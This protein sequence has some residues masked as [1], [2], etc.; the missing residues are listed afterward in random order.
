MD[1]DSSQ[2]AIPDAITVTHTVPIMTKVP[3]FENGRN[4]FRDILSTSPS[5]EVIAVTALKSTN[6]DGSPVI[7]ANVQTDTPAIGTQVLTFEALR[8]TETTAIE[9]T[10]TRI[11][12]LRTSFS[13]V[14]PSTIYNIRPVTTTILQEVDHNQLLSS[15]LLQLLGGQ[16][17]P[18]L[19]ALASTPALPAAL[20]GLGGNLGVAPKP[21]PATQF[22][23][24]TNTYVTTL[25][26]VE[27]TVL[28]ITLRGRE[29]KTTLVESKTEVVTATEFSTETIIA[30]T[31]VAPAL[32][33]PTQ[34]PQAA[35]L[36]GDLQQQLLLAQLQ[37]QLLNQQL[38]SQV[39]LD[40]E[41]TGFVEQTQVPDAPEAK[42]STSIVTLFVSG[43]KP[44][45]FTRI[46]STVT[47]TGDEES[48]ENQRY[49]RDLLLMKPSP[50]LPITKTAAPTMI[51]LSPSL[52]H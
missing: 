52:H 8:A 28:P 10:P 32:A 30:P 18:Q 4:A 33:L 34:Q 9:F 17:Q 44:G 16:K 12:G 42:P 27:S 6:I 41:G 11:R 2:N 23:T 36:G 45:D 7:Y 37:Q 50:V 14:V 39:N 20:L 25:T 29:I 15:L 46:T 51:D 35:A 3:V 48:E 31:Q 22:V 40:Q 43:S 13:H 19:P 38:L 49:K 21:V 24:H 1:L 47:L 26:N 5:L